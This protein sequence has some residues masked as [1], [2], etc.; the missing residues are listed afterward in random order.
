MVVIELN[1]DL[2]DDKLDLKNIEDK[3][4]SFWQYV[5]DYFGAPPKE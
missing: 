4:Y 1:F 5:E 2:T 3:A